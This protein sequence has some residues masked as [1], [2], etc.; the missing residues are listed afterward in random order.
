MG[1]MGFSRSIALQRL[2]RLT[3]RWEGA[4]KFYQVERGLDVPVPATARIIPRLT[5][6]ALRKGHMHS[7][8][9]IR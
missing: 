8:Y 2:L 5:W 4:F 6:N 1:V 3:H 7:I 9:R